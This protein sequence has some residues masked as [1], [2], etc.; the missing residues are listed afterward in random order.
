MRATI[1]EAST[2]VKTK[3]LQKKD[4]N[5]KLKSGRSMKGQRTDISK[6]SRKGKESAEEK[7]KAKEFAKPTPTN[8]ITDIVQAPPEITSLPRR[9][10]MS[11]SKGSSAARNAIVS[12][13]LKAQMEEEREKA[14]RRY[15]DMRESQRTA[16]MEKWCLPVKDV[17]LE[18]EDIFEVNAYGAISKQL[19]TRF[20]AFEF[21]GTCGR[22]YFPFMTIMISGER[23]V[24]S[25]ADPG[26]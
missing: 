19:L 6:S 7:G 23:V 3:Q 17:E 21:T 15:R 5:P 13:A 11:K 26:I 9:D 14:I 10:K 24:E 2:K 22:F 25:E 4:P 18:L 20:Y 16:Q 1:Q 8:R 12:L